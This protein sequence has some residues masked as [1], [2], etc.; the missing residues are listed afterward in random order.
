ML[1]LSANDDSYP[2]IGAMM[3]RGEFDVPDMSMKQMF[4]FGFERI[5]DGIDAYCE[6]R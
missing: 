2:T 4:D 1:R 6:R 5:L 3:R